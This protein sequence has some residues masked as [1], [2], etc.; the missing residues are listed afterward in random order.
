[1]RRRFTDLDNTW[2]AGLARRL[3]AMVY[4][5]F[6][7]VAIWMLM[8][9]VAV[10]LNRGEANETPLFHSLLFVATFAFFAFFWMRAGMTLGMQ[11]WRLRVQTTD[12]MSITLVQSL[13]RFLAACASLAALGLGYWWILFDAEKRSWSDIVSNTRVVVVPKQDKNKPGKK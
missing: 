5:L 8:G 6:L 11:A 2:P 9:F 13:L 4:D 12:G 1:M 10:A 3:A 7:L